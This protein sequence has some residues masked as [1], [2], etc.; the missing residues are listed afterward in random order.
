M[1]NLLGNLVHGEQDPGPADSEGAV[2]QAQAVLFCGQVHSH[3]LHEVD[4]LPVIYS[5]VQGVS[6]ACTWVGLSFVWV[7][8]NLLC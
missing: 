2:D 1:V 5:T 6:S 3:E 4:Q 8:T 7:V